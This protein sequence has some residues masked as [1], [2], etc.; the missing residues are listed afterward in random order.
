MPAF[1]FEKIKPPVPTGATPP[2]AKEQRGLLVQL[3]DRLV[4]TR[5]KRTIQEESAS[6]RQ[7]K[8]SE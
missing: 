7:K 4:E 2:V 3:L 6:A 1:T 8:S 5:T